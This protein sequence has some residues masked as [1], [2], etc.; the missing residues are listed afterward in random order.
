MLFTIID[1]SPFAQRP[2][3]ADF[4]EMTDFQVV[5]L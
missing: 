2:K 5:H 1:E 4:Y 3:K